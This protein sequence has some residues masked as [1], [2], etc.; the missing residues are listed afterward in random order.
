[1]QILQTTGNIKSLGLELPL[2]A[3]VGPMMEES[4]NWMEKTSFCETVRIQDT[5]E[6]GREG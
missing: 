4:K 1:M 2:W 6:R 3:V 5:T